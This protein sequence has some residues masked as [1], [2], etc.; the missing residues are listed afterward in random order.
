MIIVLLTWAS[1][2]FTTGIV[3]LLWSEHE[4]PSMLSIVEIYTMLDVFKVAFK[5]WINTSIMTVIFMILCAAL[6]KEK[7][8]AFDFGSFYV[9]TFA[10]LF[11]MEVWYQI[12]GDLKAKFFVNA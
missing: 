3:R 7:Y 1:L 6:F 11:N 9:W 10:V 2:I 5:W 4:F 8:K 12:I